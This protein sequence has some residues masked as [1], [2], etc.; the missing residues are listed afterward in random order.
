ME[1]K[2]ARNKARRRVPLLRFRVLPV[3]PAVVWVGV[4]LPA[5]QA[6]PRRH[7]FRGVQLLLSLAVVVGALVWL[8]PRR[9]VVPTAAVVRVRF[10]A[11]GAPL[12]EVVALEV[13]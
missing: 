8:A 7:G 6:P 2:T 5:R 10:I 12:P 4:R 13:G 3:L 11:L 1:K 9:P